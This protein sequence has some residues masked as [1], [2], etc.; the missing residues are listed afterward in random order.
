MYPGIYEGSSICGGELHHGGDRRLGLALH[1]VVGTDLSVDYRRAV[2]IFLQGNRNGGDRL[3]TP[4][5]DSFQT[6]R[7]ARL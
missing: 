4:F 7:S 6:C 3:L 2:V 1:L 5:S